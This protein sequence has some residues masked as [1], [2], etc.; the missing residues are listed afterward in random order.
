MLLLKSRKIRLLF[1][2]L[3][4]MK[5]NYDTQLQLLEFLKERG[6]LFAFLVFTFRFSINWFSPR[7]PTACFT[8]VLSFSFGQRLSYFFP[9]YGLDIR[10]I[11]D[12]LTYLPTVMYINRTISE[13]NPLIPHKYEKILPPSPPVSPF[14]SFNFQPKPTN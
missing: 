7:I 4:K 11:Q 9:S 8:K 3:I 13:K 5:G 14:C 1:K 6:R 12:C 10:Q 2:Y